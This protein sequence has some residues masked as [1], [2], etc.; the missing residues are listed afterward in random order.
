MNLW[1]EVRM[2]WR[3]KAHSFGTPKEAQVISPIIPRTTRVILGE[4][5]GNDRTSQVMF[6]ETD[7]NKNI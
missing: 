7:S 1:C 3:F 4:V 5:L 6:D 2:M